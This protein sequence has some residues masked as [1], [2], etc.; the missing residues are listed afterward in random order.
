MSNAET[1]WDEKLENDE[2][3]SKTEEQKKRTRTT[4]ITI[5]CLKP[6]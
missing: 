2:N 5:E 1:V 4:T 3:K 6:S